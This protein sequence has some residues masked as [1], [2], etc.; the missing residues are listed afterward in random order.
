MA[1]ADPEDGRRVLATAEELADVHDLAEL[2]RLRDIAFALN[3]TDA[4][5]L[6]QSACDLADGRQ[7]I[8]AIRADRVAEKRERVRLIR[9]E[10]EGRAKQLAAEVE[11]ARAER[12]KRAEP[13]EEEATR[14][15]ASFV[16]DE[17]SSAPGE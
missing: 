8:D 12:E 5:V 13:R 3:D 7:L 11:E 17:R 2:R 1:V 14:E 10:N 9:E 15:L 4:H 6:L 16:S